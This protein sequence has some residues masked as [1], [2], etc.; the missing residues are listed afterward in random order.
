MLT[1]QR[2]RKPAIATTPAI[3]TIC[4]SLQCRCSAAKIVSSTAFGVMLAAMAKSSAARSAGA[5]RPLVL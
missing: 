5:N 3:S 4:S 1:F 2:D